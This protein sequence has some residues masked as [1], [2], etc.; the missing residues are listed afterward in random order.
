MWCYLKTGFLGDQNEMTWQQGSYSHGI[1]IIRG[2]HFRWTTFAS[3][4]CPQAR[5]TLSF[6]DMVIP[7]SKAGPS[8]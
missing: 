8:P 7:Q 1:N 3:L 5:L 6:E 2:V 4:F